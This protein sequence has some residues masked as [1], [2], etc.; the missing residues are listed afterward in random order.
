MTPKLKPL[1]AL[2]ALSP[3]IICGPAR[4]LTLRGAENQ[5]VAL[6]KTQ[7]TLQG[8]VTALQSANAALADNG[9]LIYKAI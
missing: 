5:V 9:C 8:Q 3:I 6:Q 2:L 1:P 7:T 4:A